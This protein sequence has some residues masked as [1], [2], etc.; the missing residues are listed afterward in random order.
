MRCWNA[1]ARRPGHH[2]DGRL[3]PTCWRCAAATGPDLGTL[4][5]VSSRW[6]PATC[7]W[8]SPNAPSPTAPCITPVD[9]DA[10]TTAPRR[11]L[12]ERRRRGRFA[13][14]SSTPMPTT[15]TNGSALE[16]I[17]AR[18]A[19]RPRHRLHPRSSRRSANSSAPRP[20]SLN[21]YLQPTVGAYLQ[22]LEGALRQPRE[23]DWAGRPDRAVE[24]RRDVGR[25]RPPPT[26][27]H[28]ALSGPA[29]GVIA[30]AYIAT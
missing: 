12:L 9:V 4:G 23:F 1:R 26:G 29:A 18:L 2:H 7:G 16:A 20:P 24:R 22:R 3:S 28:H 5:H 6:C 21:A 15:P 17:R 13:S 27:A 14:A 10:V 8:R 11:T 25:H 19:Q 30:G